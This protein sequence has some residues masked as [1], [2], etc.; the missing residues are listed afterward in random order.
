MTAVENGVN[1]FDTA[2]MY[3]G[4]EEA[5][6]TVLEKNRIRDKVYIAAKLPIVFVKKTADFDRYFDEELRRLR[7]GRIDYYLMHMLTD[8]ASWKRLLALGID[9][10][11]AAGK[12]SGKIG[13][14]GFS[15]HGSGDEFLKLLEAYPWEFCQI[16]YNYSDENFQAGVRGLKKA[17]ETMPVIIMEPLLG[18]KLANALPAAAI[19]I[20]RSFAA[21]KLSPAGWGLRW[22]WNQS[23]AALVLSGMSDTAQVIEN[24][25]LA[26]RTSAGSLGEAELDVYRRVRDVFNAAYKVHCTGCGYCMPCPR[27]VNIPG[28]FGAYNTFFSMGKIVGWQQY[29]TSA[30]FTSEKSRGPANC[31]ACG[32]CE[33][34]CPQ[35][36]PIVENLKQLRKRMEPLWFRITIAAVRFFLG[37][38]KQPESADHAA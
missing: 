14:I 22:V 30:G 8:L 31:I 27:D 32:T 3:P 11:I 36:L 26:E 37:M 10:W 5:L 24:A 35:K 15:F 23:E 28:C 17:A 29:M 25:E 13:Q 20:F 18:G 6:G 12:K 4:S 34:H 38:G 33:S 7:T 1:Y 9:E 2:W 21:E 19:D 16:Q